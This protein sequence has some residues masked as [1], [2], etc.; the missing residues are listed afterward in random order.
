MVELN[1][2]RFDAER[3]LST[4]TTTV[5]VREG[6]DELY[7][8]YTEV[9]R[10]RAYPMTTL[11]RLLAAAGFELLAVHGLSEQFQ[12]LAGGLEPYNEEHGRVVMVARR[13]CTEDRSL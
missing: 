10:E 8:R 12:G 3:A 2:Y 6:E 7:R 1:H 5:F 9:H 13:T 4:V 11:S